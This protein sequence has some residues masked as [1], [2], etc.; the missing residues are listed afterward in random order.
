MK[1]EKL[2]LL[3]D[4]NNYKDL[5]KKIENLKNITNEEFAALFPDL[6]PKTDYLKACEE[7][8]DVL[9][10]G[11]AIYELR[12]IATL[13]NNHSGLWFKFI[14]LAKLEKSVD[15][16]T[17]KLKDQIVSSTNRNEN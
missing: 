12:L 6:E 10:G 5:K 9:T 2:Y 4:C 16:E 15:D 13:R 17:Q 14:K 7:I 1:K 3:D 11:L 8:Y